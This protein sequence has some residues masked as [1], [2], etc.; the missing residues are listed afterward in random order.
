MAAW[1]RLIVPITSALTVNVAAAE[2][3]IHKTLTD[4]LDRYAESRPGA[5]R[6]DISSQVCSA[7]II[8]SL[9]ALA[10][11]RVGNLRVKKVAEGRSF[12]PGAPNTTYVRLGRNV[13]LFD[14]QSLVVEFNE[15][16]NFCSAVI[17]RDSGL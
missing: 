2:I 10:S 4:I 3:V 1:F 17:T 11:G 5:Y 9:D 16:E 15:E 14:F 8:D 13:G 6:E 7:E 12:I